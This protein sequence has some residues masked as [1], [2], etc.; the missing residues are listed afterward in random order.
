MSGT[1][2]VL[3]VNSR[4][5]NESY[6]A[7]LLTP[8]KQTF[9]LLVQDEQRVDGSQLGSGDSLG[10]AC[11][12]T[13]QDLP[14]MLPVPKCHG[15]MATPASSGETQAQS[16]LQIQLEMDYADLNKRSI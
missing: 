8:R 4:S 9:K 10:R 7:P 6:L 3:T 1:E 15:H 14:D 12:P 16:D 5:I 2:K 13:Q 11:S